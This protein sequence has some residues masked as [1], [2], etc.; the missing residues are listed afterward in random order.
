M[1]NEIKSIDD[2]IKAAFDFAQDSTKQLITLSSGIIALTITFQKDFIGESVNAE[3]KP[4][5]LGSWLLLLLSVFFGLWTLLTLTG[6]LESRGSNIQPSI[7]GK[8]IAIPAGLLI[9]SFF[10]GL[11]L[12]VVFGFKSMD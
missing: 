9:L 2:R 6:S 8:N 5:L 3:A 7:Y 1:D 12:T 4:Y 10:L 11:C